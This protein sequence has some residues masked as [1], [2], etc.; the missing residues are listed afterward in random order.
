MDIV[1]KLDYRQGSL[2]LRIELFRIEVQ[3]H[4]ICFENIF[5]LFS[6]QLN[7]EDNCG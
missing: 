4:N 6:L 2:I 3:S 7:K 1:L 5:K